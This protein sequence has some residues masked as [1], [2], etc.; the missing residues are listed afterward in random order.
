MERRP[1]QPQA[2]DHEHRPMERPA[3]AFGLIGDVQYMDEDDGKKHN[4]P[5]H[6]GQS[7]HVRKHYRGALTVLAKAVNYFDAFSEP[8]RFVANLGDLI[9][10][11]NARAGKSHS[12]LSQVMAVVS[13]S[14]VPFVHLV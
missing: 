5:Y 3:F 11:R 13:R 8:L 12:A 9:D 10:G 14:R 7:G 2:A 4:H 6:T 1:S